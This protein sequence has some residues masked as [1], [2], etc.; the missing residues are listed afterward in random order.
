MSQISKQ[1]D[2]K[3]ETYVHSNYKLTRILQQTNGQQYVIGPGGG[4]E[5]IFEIPVKALNFA[6]S[7]LY[8]SI[9]PPALVNP[10]YAANSASWFF[11]D[12]VAAIQQIQLYNRGG[13]PICDLNYV[14]N[15]TKVVNKVETPMSEF[16]NKPTIQDTLINNQS[17]GEVLGRTNAPRDS[18]TRTLDQPFAMRFDNTASSLHF[19]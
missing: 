13:I 5:S 11:T 1:L 3:K 12:C 14:S 7:Y 16:L 10:P 4:Y 8:F 9:T 6:Q 19:T 17:V 18:D 15:Y 2:Y